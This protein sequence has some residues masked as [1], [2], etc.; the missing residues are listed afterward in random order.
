M[1]NHDAAKKLPPLNNLN[2][3]LDELND[4]MQQNKDDLMFQTEVDVSNYNRVQPR[5]ITSLK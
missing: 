5:S 4:E 1:K 3:S 2:R